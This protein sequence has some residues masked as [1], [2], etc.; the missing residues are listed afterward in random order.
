MK[1]K[2][3][4]HAEYAAAVKQQDYWLEIYAEAL[5]QYEA[6]S[7]TRTEW[8]SDQWVSLWAVRCAAEDAVRATAKARKAVLRKRA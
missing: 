7:S 1:A 4:Y 8:D 2:R 6:G 3:D 5:A